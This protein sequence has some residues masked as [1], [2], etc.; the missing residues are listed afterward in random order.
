MFCNMQMWPNTWRRKLIIFHF[1]CL[2]NLVEYHCILNSWCVFVLWYKQNCFHLFSVWDCKRWG[3]CYECW[4][5]ADAVQPGMGI[6]TVIPDC[7]ICPSGCSPVSHGKHPA[8]PG[9]S[10]WRSRFDMCGMSEQALCVVLIQAA[11]IKHR[12]AWQKTSNSFDCMIPIAYSL[13]S[14]FLTL[15]F[16]VLCPPFPQ[17]NLLPSK[18]FSPNFF[19]SMLVPVLLHPYAD[20]LFVIWL[21]K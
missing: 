10:G 14:H 17:S 19:F 7:P 8:H 6:S 21:P 16:V 9:P 5:A 11:V 12:A 3:G 15:V 13:F 4:V 1:F 18:Q 20:L 2:N